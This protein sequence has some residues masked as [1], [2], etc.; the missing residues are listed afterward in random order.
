METQNQNQIQ[1]VI[2]STNINSGGDLELE[3]YIFTFTIISLFFSTFFIFMI[4]KKPTSYAKI[5]RLVVVAE[6]IC[7]FSLLIFVCESIS[8][9]FIREYSVKFFHYLTFNLFLNNDYDNQE[10]L[11]MQKI[12]IRI[13]S[14][15]FYSMEI[16]SIFLS[17][18]ICLEIILVLKNPIAAI[19]N[20]LKIYFIFV[21]FLGMLVFILVFI[22]QEFDMKTIE[23]KRDDINFLYKEI[24]FS[25]IG[26]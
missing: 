21:Q 15:M 16:F 22:Y 18:F 7:Q 19:T 20:R 4:N 8:W 24:F 23:T 26:R 14:A 25:D 10:Y 6:A 13:N 2:K 3:K 17:S 11:K 9:L 1:I 12:L 5:L